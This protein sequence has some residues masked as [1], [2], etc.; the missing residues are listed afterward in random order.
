MGFKVTIYFDKCTGD[1]ICNSVCPA[2][3]FGPVEDGKATIVKPDECIGCKACE[4]QCPENAIV[5]DEE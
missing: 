2:D 4:A 3:V 1:G 5:I